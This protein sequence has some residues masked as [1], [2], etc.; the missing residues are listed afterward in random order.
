[1]FAAGASLATVL[2]LGVSGWFITSAAIAGAAG[3]VAAH[4]FNF[5]LPSAFIRLLAIVRTAT[6]YGERLMAHAYALGTLSRVRARLFRAIT[7]LPIARALAL[8]Q[9]DALGRLVQD[10]GVLEARLVRGAAPWS[11]AAALAGGTT[12][13]VVGGW[14]AVAMLVGLAVLHLA[15]AAWLARLLDRAGQDVEVVSAELKQR[16]AEFV[17]AGPELACMGLHPWV[18]DQLMANDLSLRDAQRKRT[19]RLAWFE[20]LGATTMALA[21]GAGLML[22]AGAGAPIAALCAL[23]AAMASEGLTPLVRTLAERSAERGAADRL[24]AIIGAAPTPAA[25]LFKVPPA[26]TL[27]QPDGRSF[28]SGSVI[29]LR[30]PSGSGKTTLLETLLGLREARPGIAALD[31]IDIVWIPPQSRRACFAWAPQDAALLTGTVRANLSVAC[32]EA[33]EAAMWRALDD[34]LLTARVRAMPDRLDSWIGE[35]GVRLSGGERRRLSLARAYVSQAPW[36]LLDEPTE[37]LDRT[38]AQQVMR[39]LERRLQES[40]QGCVIVSHHHDEL[41]C[42]KGTSLIH[43]Q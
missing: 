19:H 1:M 2:L 17:A 24:R 14:R 7:C 35:D 31:G 11:A 20:M 34:A 25:I 37:G 38:T 33:D 36:L 9:G 13:L 5:M 18:Q 43:G 28:A 39:N 22:A 42:L 15:V 21:G 4:A 29:K 26:L 27:S 32:P 30:G 12:L 8:G 16:L 23:A 40:G 41:A 3:A 6:R 10:V